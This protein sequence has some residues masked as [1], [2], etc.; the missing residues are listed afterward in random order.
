MCP[1]HG[2]GILGVHFPVPVILLLLGCFSF[3]SARSNVEHFFLDLCTF[4]SCMGILWQLPCFA[5]CCVLGIP[6]LRVHYA[7]INCSCCFSAMWLQFPCANCLELV[8]VL[9]CP[10][11]LPLQSYTFPLV[12]PPWHFA[13]RPSAVVFYLFV[14]LL[15][16]TLV[17]LHI[18]CR[19][20]VCCFTARL[21]VP[22]LGGWAILGGALTEGD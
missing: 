21:G 22:C 18:V 9:A 1:R 5:V 13:S 6:W 20:L 12:G 16:L 2:Q 3:S 19:H 14:I 10:W 17:F 4:L 8:L 15:R 11:L 7:D